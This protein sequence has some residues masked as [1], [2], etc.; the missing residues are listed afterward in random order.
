MLNISENTVEIA[1]EKYKSFGKIALANSNVKFKRL[2][3]FLLLIFL[4]ILFLPWTQNIQSKGKLTTISPEHRPQTIHSTIAGRVE[5][6]YVREGQKVRKGDTILRLSEVKTDYF[7]PNLISRTAQQVEAKQGAVGSY[8]SKA[9]ALEQQITATRG[10]L[11]FKKSQL[12]NKIEQAKLKAEADKN[13]LAAANIDLET[14]TKQLKRTEEMFKEGL[15]SLTEV[16]N[17]RLKWQQTQAKQISSKNKYEQSI[18]EIDNLKF[19]LD[20]VNSEYTGKIAKTES[21]KYST[22][23]DKFDAEATVSK[24]QNLYSN[25]VWR[26]Q[27]Y[28]IIAPQDCIISLATTAGLGETVKEGEPVVSIVPTDMDLAVEMFIDPLDLPL[29]H[30]RPD[31]EVR[32]IFDGW[33]AFVFSGWPSASIGT[34]SGK[35][36]GVDNV[37]NKE[38]KYRLLIAP[39]DN[40]PAWPTELRPGSGAKG[41]ILLNDVS[42]W[43]EMWRQ[44]N[45]FPADFYKNEEKASD[46][47]EKK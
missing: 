32:F 41:F 8:A 14:E 44:I 9:D 17:K 46:K 39:N 37:A 18:Q 24:L 42:V 20:G 10:E 7:D 40:K 27:F 47:K 31:A 28:Y 19:Q 13:D 45:G 23:S 4:V 43:Y 16:E 11:S 33:P 35:I 2:L 38:G 1:T 30:N 12:L 34:Y 5:Q 25:Y 6:W 21:E 29:V 36:I 15:K 26:Q 3:M 22:L